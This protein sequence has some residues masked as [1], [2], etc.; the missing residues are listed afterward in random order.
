MGG[1]ITALKL[2][3]KNS[4]RINV[5]LDDEFGFGV[6]RVVAAGLKLG[7]QLDD[8]AISELKRKDA[9]EE[10]YQRAL[11]LIAR[12]PHAERELR[13]KLQRKQLDQ[14]V[15][16]PVIERLKDHDWLD[17][18]AFAAA[19][20]ENR[21]VFRPRSARALRSELR[22]KGISREIIEEALA[23]YD[24]ASAAY[25]AGQKAARRWS[26]AERDV[27]F[28]KVGSYLARRGFA[29]ATIAPVVERLWLETS[30]DDEESEDD[31]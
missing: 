14:S 12:R 30:G 29:Y 28:K 23:D 2:Q 6:A 17:D 7:Q 25:D 1:M 11:R 16:D 15:L 4:R 27:F 19:W 10:A 18:A 24:D 3:K 5:Y 21:R 22:G 8:D 9:E 13:R 31:Q 26:Q 20:V